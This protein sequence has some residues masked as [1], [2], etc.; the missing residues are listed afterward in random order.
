[1]ST[2]FILRDPTIFPSPTRFL[3][4]RWLL[5][6]EE[7]LRLQRY[8]VPASKGTLG[9][10]GQNIIPSP[11]NTPSL[12]PSP[13]ALRVIVTVTVTVGTTPTNITRMVY[14]V[15]SMNAAWMHL[16]LGTLFRRYELA[17][18]ATTQANVEMTRDNFIGQTAFG[19]NNVQVRVVGVVG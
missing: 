8:L 4:D 19:A 7:A 17:L 13:L 10:L 14:G 18:H 3:P 1:M 12:P 9:C 16:V 2:Y 6:P 5:A 15:C 11:L